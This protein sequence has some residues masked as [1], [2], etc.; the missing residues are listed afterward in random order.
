MDDPPSTTQLHAAAPSTQQPVAALPAFT[1]PALTAFAGPALLA[2]AGPPLPALPL[3][4][5][6]LAELASNRSGKII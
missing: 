2:F 3:S 6:N 1:G 5:A 4:A